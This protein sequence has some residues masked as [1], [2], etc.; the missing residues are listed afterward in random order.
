M[1]LI[2]ICIPAY[3]HVDYL[4]K[5]LDSVSIQTFKDFE[6][7]I[8]DDSPDDGVKQLLETFPTTNNIR[9]YKNS[10]ALG[11]PENWNE[12]IRKSEG[13]WIKLM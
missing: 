9:Y 7:V 12:A 1:P 2:S 3:K 11:T 13:T 4:K 6:V 8:T 10:K 5:L